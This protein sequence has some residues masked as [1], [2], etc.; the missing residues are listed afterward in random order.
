MNSQL[1][2]RHLKPWC[3]TMPSLNIPSQEHQT[4]RLFNILLSL[5]AHGLFQWKHILRLVSK[6][7]GFTGVETTKKINVLYFSDGSYFVVLVSWSKKWAHGAVKVGLLLVPAACFVMSPLFHTCFLVLLC[8][9]AYSHIRR[10]SPSAKAC[11]AMLL[12][13]KDIESKINL[14]S[15]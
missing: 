15:W 1:Y 13:C 10:P 6:V 14:Y 11:S 2:L 12:D 4:K 8:H 9:L 3:Y 5:F 7:T